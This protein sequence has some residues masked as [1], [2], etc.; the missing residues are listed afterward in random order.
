MPV[1]YYTSQVKG[2]RHLIKPFEKA[3]IES[4]RIKIP[5]E[6]FSFSFVTLCKIKQISNTARFINGTAPS[7]AMQRHWL[8][9]LDQLK[10]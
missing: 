5:T 10:R 7:C 1:H 3:Q 9:T 6:H 2:R 4:A 8:K